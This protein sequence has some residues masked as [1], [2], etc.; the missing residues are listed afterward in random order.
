[1]TSAGG[2]IGMRGAREK[3]VSLLFS[4]PVGAL[5]KGVEIGNGLEQPNVITLD[6]GGT[7]ADVGVAPQG[8]M[9]HKHILDTRIG[10]YDAMVPMVDLSTIGAGGGSIASVDSAG[11][12]TVGPNS[13]G[14]R[15]GPACFGYGG[16]DAT[17]TDALLTLGWYREE[18][19]T[20][21]GIAVNRELAAEAILRN[22]ADPLALSLEEAA[23]GIYRIASRNMIDAIRVGSI[24][25]GFDARDFILVAFGGAGASFVADIAEELSISAAVVPP[26]P[27]VGAAAGLLSSDVRY[28]FM[29]SCWGAIDDFPNPDFEQKVAAMD[30]QARTELK[31]DGFADADTDI[32]FQCDCRYEG[33]GYELTVDMPADFRS[34]HWRSMLAEAFHEAHEHH[35]L[36]RFDDKPVRII[37][38]RVVGIGSVGRPARTQ[39]VAAGDNKPVTGAPC[40]FAGQEGWQSLQTTFHDRSNLTSGTVLNG[41]IVVEQRDTTTIVPPGFNLRVD[42]SGNLIITRGR[43]DE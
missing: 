34:E 12:F 40:I 7:S 2:L 5:I 6:V 38:V 20:R 10:D 41:P 3:P 42:P 17:V 21:S 25:K 22:V 32:R 39:G 9:L 33:Q 26:R 35:Y 4:G 37:N 24:S 16:T 15:P 1:M 18:T 11:M 27:G 30:A 23:L 36:R 14:A 28:E 8:R 29:A 13:A 19:F 31:R 43:D